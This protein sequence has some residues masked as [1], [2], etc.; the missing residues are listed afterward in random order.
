MAFYIKDKRQANFEQNKKRANELLENRENSM[1]TFSNVKLFVAILGFAIGAVMIILGWKLGVSPTEDGEVT[2]GTIALVSGM[3]SCAGSVLALIA[4]RYYQPGP[5][6]ISALIFFLA[7][8]L[9]VLH[10]DGTKLMRGICLPEGIA[11]LIAAFYAKTSFDA[12]KQKGLQYK[13]K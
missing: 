1:P 8:L 2:A 12:M 3:F 11:G 5:M 6:V 4:R 13:K 10:P 7:L 9:A